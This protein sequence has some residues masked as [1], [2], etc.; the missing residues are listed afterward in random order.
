MCSVPAAMFGMQAMGQIGQA[1]ETN[2][3]VQQGIDSASRS[4]NRQREA[5]ARAR[6]QRIMAAESKINDLLERADSASSEVV[7]SGLEGGAGGGAKDDTFLEYGRLIG[8][9]E[10]SIRTQTAYGIQQLDFDEEDAVEQTKNRMNELKSKAVT[11][12][13]LN[14]GLAQSA[15]GAHMMGGQAGYYDV[16][17][18]SIFSNPFGL[19]I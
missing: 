14:I 13:Q 3:A 19:K 7:L 17:E 12:G 4:L 9:Q 16:A 2:K 18:T 11:S 15:L 6:H 1:K 8:R 10:S 5:L